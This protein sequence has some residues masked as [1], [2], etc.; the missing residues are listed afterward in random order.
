MGRL[1]HFLHHLPYSSPIMLRYNDL[2]SHR[3]DQGLIKYRM[4]GLVLERRAT[5]WNPAC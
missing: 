2:L 3:L 1:K 4:M 5:S